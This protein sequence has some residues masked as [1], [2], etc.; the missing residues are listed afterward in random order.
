MAQVSLYS[1]KVTTAFF[2]LTTGQ[3]GQGLWF[4]GL[5]LG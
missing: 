4:G 2:A 1:D 5:G 3:K